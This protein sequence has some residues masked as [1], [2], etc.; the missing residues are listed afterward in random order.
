[1]WSMVEDIR[2]RTVNEIRIREEHGDEKIFLY[3]VG[4]IGEYKAVTYIID[5]MSHNCIVNRL[6][7]FLRK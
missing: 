4:Y 7:S 5:V 6:L 3:V 1:M 2:K